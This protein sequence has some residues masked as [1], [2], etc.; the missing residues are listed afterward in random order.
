[1]TDTEALLGSRLV[2]VTGKG[3]TGKT[4]F[5]S[6]LALL[7]ATRGRRVLLCEIDAQHSSIP[8]I[9]GVE[10]G[11]D[12][13][14]AGPG[15]DVANLRFEPALQRFLVELVP[16]RRIV[17]MVLENAAAR[18]FL[19]FTPGSREL[20]VLSA[21][22][23][24]VERYDL[25][26]VDMPASGHAFSLL[27]ITRSALGL[28]RSGPVRR[29]A[30][31]LRRMLLAPE[32]RM[33]LVALPEEM[34]VNETLETRDRLRAYELLGQPPMVFLNRATAP[35]M[36]ALERDLL[37]RLS[38]LD[39]SGHAAE[40]VRAGRWEAR[41]EQGTAD[42]IDRLGTIGTPI[43]VPTVKAGSSPEHVVAEVATTL[44]RTAGVTRRDLQRRGL[45]PGQPW[46]SNPTTLAS[47]GR[48]GALPA[49]WLDDKRLVICV[50]AGGVGKTTTAAALALRGARR[51]RRAIVLTIDPARRL[52]N[53]L[54]ISELGNTALQI[55]LEEPT[56]GEL[57]AMM[58]DSRQAFDELL[59]RILP[60]PAAREKIRRN[61]VYQHMSGAFAG[62][63]DYV[64]AEKLYDLATSGRW[65][66]VVLDT[67]PVK[68]ALDFLESPG[69]LVH[70]LDERILRW[71]LHPYDPSHLGGR[72]LLG[73]SAV[74]YKLLGYVFGSD[75]L[76]DLGRFFRDFEGL[77]AGFRERHQQVL[78]LF[79]AP[80]T[81][82]LAVCAPTETT[83]DV[84]SFFIDE[85]QRRRLPLGGV[86]VN[87]VH[88]CEHEGHDAREML[89]RLLTELA[90]DR[91]EAERG[92]LL[93]RLGMAHRRLHEIAQA[94]AAATWRIRSRLDA[95]AAYVEIP[96]LEAEVHDLVGLEHLGRALLEISDPP[97]KR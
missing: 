15:L 42:A 14:P 94:D 53:S 96:R 84:A 63:Q 39:L 60:D 52:A 62:S 58:L 70:F 69:R 43:L 3:G 65:D 56:E 41:L 2:M 5:A 8:S 72:L 78:D 32:T 74:V 23:K 85:L 44:G 40:F 7:A 61:H 36:G 38:A 9:F 59:E 34:V 29:R 51:G 16:S 80:E 25:V 1:M 76:D 21:V 79:H 95:E 17:R 4:T 45:P 26:V 13:R 55:P 83:L 49:D 35:S 20:V 50:G 97:E 37:D 89:E 54:G 11:F 48:H 82:F 71:F 57:W 18:R 88:G 75:F 28:F 68:N 31:Q 91:T 66:L 12:P 27:D 22:G 33:A 64:A 86:V 93:A 30:A 73:T 24:L 87:Q 92:G 47:P 77:Y 6:A 90:P 67:P 19:D 46:K 81:A 10:P